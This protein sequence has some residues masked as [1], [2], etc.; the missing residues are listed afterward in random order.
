[1]F[2]WK[3]KAKKLAPASCIG[4]NAPLFHFPREFPDACESTTI[5]QLRVV[6]RGPVCLAGAGRRD[7][8]AAR[9]G[10]RPI[11]ALDDLHRARAGHA[12]ATREATHAAPDPLPA[13]PA[14]APEPDGS[15]SSPGFDESLK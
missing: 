5:A 14:A 4:C 15:I 9:P 2:P 11:D 7:G 13:Q 3:R 8:A 1:M 12:L 6:Q 10:R